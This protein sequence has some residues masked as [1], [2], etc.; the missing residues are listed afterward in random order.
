MIHLRRR[1]VRL[2]LSSVTIITKIINLHKHNG[3]IPS[4]KKFLFLSFLFLFLFHLSFIPAQRETWL[5][6]RNGM[7]FAM[8]D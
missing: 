4:R 7:G 8:A 5:Q 6:E 2:I 3:T 1:A